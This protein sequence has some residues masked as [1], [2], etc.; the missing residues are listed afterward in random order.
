MAFLSI[1]LL[2]FILLGGTCSF[3]THHITRSCTIVMLE[4]KARSGLEKFPA[5]EG[6]LTRI[7]NLWDG[8]E[9]PH[10][11]VSCLSACLHLGHQKGH[12]DECLSF[13]SLPGQWLLP[14]LHKAQEICLV[15]GSMV[16]ALHTS[17]EAPSYFTVIVSLP[18]CHLVWLV[19]T[20]R[21]VT[22]I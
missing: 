10:I 11:I 5:W 12:L 2:S 15:P 18:A 4:S 16:D 20:K 13:K 22:L 21:A 9:L 1:S 6:R 14:Q 3:S 7:D 19:H 17:M 8:H